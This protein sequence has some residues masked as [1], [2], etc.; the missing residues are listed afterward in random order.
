M[1]VVLLNDDLSSHLNLRYE[2]SQ[3]LP[4]VQFPSWVGVRLN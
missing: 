1:F 4:K 2:P 3:L